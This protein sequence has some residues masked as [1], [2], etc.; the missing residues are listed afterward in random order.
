[1]I[2]Q[3]IYSGNQT[4]NFIEIARFVEDTVKNILVSFV[5]II[6]LLCMRLSENLVRR[7][8]VGPG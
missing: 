8:V 7:S 2:L 3:Q 4:P 5:C 6:H 1:M